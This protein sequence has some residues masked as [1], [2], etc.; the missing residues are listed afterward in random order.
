MTGDICARRGLRVQ[1]LQ[2]WRWR[3]QQGPAQEE[4]VAERAAIQVVEH[5]FRELAAVGAGKVS[6]SS[7]GGFELRWPDG[8]TLWIPADFEAAALRRLLAALEAS[9]C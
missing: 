4:V 1:T 8:L 5:G 2:W 7:R 9:P 3:L 6:A